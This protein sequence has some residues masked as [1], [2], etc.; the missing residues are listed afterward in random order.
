MKSKNKKII[1]HDVHDRD[2]SSVQK[3]LAKIDRQARA[4]I[5]SAIRSL[6]NVSVGHRKE[7]YRSRGTRGD[8]LRRC[9]DD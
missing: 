9:D 5:I 2:L 3:H 1:I 7:V 8:I 6:A 4:A